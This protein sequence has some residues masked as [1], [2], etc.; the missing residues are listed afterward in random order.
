MKEIAK[1]LHIPVIALSQLNRDLEKRTDK[2]PCM[3]D[4]RGSGALE[5][6]ADVIMFLYRDEVYHENSPE[7]GI[8]EVIIGKQRNGPVGKVRLFYKANCTRFENLSKR[9]DYYED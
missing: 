2:R 8:A 3:A 5:Q 4:L 6:D 1:D 9:G 7:K